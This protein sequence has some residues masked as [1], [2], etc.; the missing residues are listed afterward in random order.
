M[1]RLAV[2]VLLCCSTVIAACGGSGTKASSGT[3]VRVVTTTTQLT[4]F[5]RA[6]GGGHVR[7]DGLLKPNVDPHDYEP[8]PADLKAI[9]DADLIVRNGVGVEGWFDDTIKSASP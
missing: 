8:T 3:M 5:A 9:G 4:D 6:V 7:V 2:T 1:R